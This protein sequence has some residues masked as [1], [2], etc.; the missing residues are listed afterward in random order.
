MFL[1][2]YY[3]LESDCTSKAYVLRRC[4]QLVVTL[5]EPLGGKSNRKGL[6]DIIRT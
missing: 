3:S 4:P 6:E 1:T 2:D 5:V